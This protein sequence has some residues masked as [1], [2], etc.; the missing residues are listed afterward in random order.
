[1]SD[2]G[3]R[4]AAFDPCHPALALRVVLLVQAALAVLVLAGAADAA[5]GWQRRSMRRWARW[6][7]CS[8]LRGWSPLTWRRVAPGRARRRLSAVRAALEAGGATD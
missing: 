3:A 5:H 2:P 8:P 7:P 4:S 6:R 1:M